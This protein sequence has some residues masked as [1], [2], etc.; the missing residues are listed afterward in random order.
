MLQIGGKIVR[1]LGNKSR[2]TDF[3]EEVINKYNITGEIFADLFSGSGAVG[4]YFKDR[5]TIL[6]ND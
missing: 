6:S 3:I 5:Y 2:L 1:Y 4:D